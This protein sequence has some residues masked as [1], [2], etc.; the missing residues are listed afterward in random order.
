M[1]FAALA[2]LAAAAALALPA[3]A[4]APTLPKFTDH[5]AQN[6]AVKIHYA[7]AGDASKPLVVMIHGFPDYWYTWR[8]LMAELAP[9]YR[10]VAI[11][12]RGYNLSDKP[13][14][15]PAYAMPNLVGDVEAVIH[16][17][18]RKSAIVVGHDWGAS[19]AWNTVL[20]KPQL[21]DRL[22]IMS[23]PHP[24]NMARE[25]KNNPIQQQS[26]TYAHNFQKEGS[27]KNI[28]L[29]TIYG[30]MKD[31]AAK[32]AYA[33]AFAQSSPAAMMAYYKA[34]YPADV[35]DKVVIPTFPKIKV[36]VFVIH[37]MQDTALRAP[38]HNGTWDQVDADTTILMLPK[39]GHWIEQDAGPI[40]NKAIHD[41]LN[42]R[43]VDPK[44]QR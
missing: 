32:P 12:T 29:A 33:K 20:S 34:N 6:G 5:Y 16:A 44:S 37:G 14:G 35:G 22:I 36:P 40:A 24:A 9:Q 1:K 25:L 26:S 27:E 8:N 11:D 7:S 31:D 30:W 15:V 18:G 13:D 42:E 4:A 28:N 39:A 41:W 23:V 43:P 17:E 21:V 2:G 19:I 38:G 10:V 3:T